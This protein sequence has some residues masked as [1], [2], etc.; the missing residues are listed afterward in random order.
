MW[1][2]PCSV[3]QS[4]DDEREQVAEAIEAKTHVK[5]S[6][7]AV[8]S[9]GAVTLFVFM[10]FGVGTLFCQVVSFVYPFYGS[11]MSIEKN[12]A[13]KKTCWLKYWGEL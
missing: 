7:F 13:S 11:V 9:C 2:S 10:V 4:N 1:T 12:D 5:A 8:G 3:C 6:L